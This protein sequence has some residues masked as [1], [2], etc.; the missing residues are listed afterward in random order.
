MADSSADSSRDPVARERPGT[1]RWVK[2]LGIAALVVV[3][4][5]VVL[6]LTGAGGE[7]GPSRHEAS[8]DAG[9]RQTLFVS[10]VG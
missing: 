4:L 10:A 1:P 3:L 9:A 2:A 6:M 8:S 7:H 5:L